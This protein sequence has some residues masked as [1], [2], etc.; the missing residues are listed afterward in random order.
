[1]TRAAAVLTLVLISSSAFAQ[2]HQPYAGMQQREV[3]ALSEQ[4]VSD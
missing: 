1:M 2:N 4:Q 3:K